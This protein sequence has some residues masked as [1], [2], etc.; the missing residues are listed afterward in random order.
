MIDYRQ[1]IVDAAVKE[2][3]HQLGD[4]EVSQARVAEHV[5]RAALDTS[6]EKLV[7][8]VARAIAPNSN[9]WEEYR[10]Q[11]MDAIAAMWGETISILDPLP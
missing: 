8:E 10:L 1:T 7:Q 6:N 11:A 5:L 4:D 3:R 9:D 2:L